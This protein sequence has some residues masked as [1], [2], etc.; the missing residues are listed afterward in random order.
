MINKHATQFSKNKFVSHVMN[1]AA[2]SHTI[3]REW[4]KSIWFIKIDKNM[5]NERENTWNNNNTWIGMQRILDWESLTSAMSI[6]FH[7]SQQF[8]HNIHLGIYL[9]DV[10]ISPIHHFQ[11]WFCIMI[12]RNK[13]NRCILMPR[14]CPFLTHI[15]WAIEYCLI[16]Q[17]TLG[18]QFHFDY[19]CFR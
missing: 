15:L 10:H 3:Y 17:S 8:L 1:C 16:N 4:L 13:W 6:V 19:G 12:Y 18:R 14:N 9:A 7:R 5:Q 2:K 11:C